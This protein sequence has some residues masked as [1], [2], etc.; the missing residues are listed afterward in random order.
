M[1][2]RKWSQR[3]SSLLL[4]DLQNDTATLQTVWQCLIKLNVLSKWFSKSLVFTQRLMSRH[5]LC[6]STNLNTD[7]Y[8]NFIYNCPNSEAA[9]MSF[10]RWMDQLWKIQT[11]EYYLALKRNELL[12]KVKTWRRLKRILLSEG[13]QSEKATY[14][15]TPTI[16]YSEKRQNCGDGKNMSGFQEL[17]ARGKD[18]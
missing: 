4:G 15:M 11:V 9:K 2:V 12:G 5:T 6:P 3:S 17:G 14:Y 8:S 10:S 16:L 1:P 18:E 13:C 7:I